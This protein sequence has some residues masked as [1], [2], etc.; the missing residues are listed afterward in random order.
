MYVYHINIYHWTYPSEY[1]CI[2]I[3]LFQLFINSN[4][5]LFYIFVIVILLIYNNDETSA[6]TLTIRRNDGGA[7]FLYETNAVLLGIV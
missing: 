2:N 5:L 4:Y 7:V 6:E 3:L 1:F